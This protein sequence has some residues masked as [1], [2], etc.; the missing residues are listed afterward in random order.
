M[1]KKLIVFFKSD[2]FYMSDGE[3]PIVAFQ[4]D[5]YT[6]I[7]NVPIYHHVWEN[8][9][10]VKA[11]LSAFIKA[12]FHFSKIFRPKIYIIIPDD[13]IFVDK[14]CIIEFLF[15]MGSFKEP[16]MINECLLLANN[17]LLSYIAL[18]KSE[19]AISISLIKDGEAVDTKYFDNNFNDLDEIKKEIGFMKKDSEVIN[20]PV[21]LYGED[22]SIFGE[23]GEE[24]SPKRM[25]SNF[26][27][28]LTSKKDI[29]RNKKRI[30]NNRFS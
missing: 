10:T 28:L 11:E 27:F 2:G 18:T 20:A 29:K 22:M 7:P 24:I 14:R 4:F 6:K 15:S 21:Y 26:L 19:R 30:K 5:G 8:H 23:L 13:A 9:K 12:N 25:L 16:T 1:S 3:K 17:P